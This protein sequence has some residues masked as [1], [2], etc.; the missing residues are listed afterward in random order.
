MRRGAS[1]GDVEVVMSSA[2][3]VE[4]LA[5]AA[6]R[7]TASATWYYVQATAET[8]SAGASFGDALLALSFALPELV[9]PDRIADLLRQVTVGPV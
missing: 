4:E 5:A 1:E 2:R 3:D 8:R 6:R 7:L 9:A